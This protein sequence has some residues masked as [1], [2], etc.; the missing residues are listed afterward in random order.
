MSE[1]L[2]LGREP[3]PV[4][5]QPLPVAPRGFW[6]RFRLDYEAERATGLST[7]RERNYALGF[8]QALADVAETLPD[9]AGGLANPYADFAGGFGAQLRGLLNLSPAERDRIAAR[10]RAWDET[11]ERLIAERP[12]LAEKLPRAADIRARADRR[13]RELAEQ[14]KAAVGF[15]GGLGGFLGTAAAIF[16]DPLQ[17]LTLA[18]G[19]GRPAGS[20]LRQIGKA[21]LIEGV[22]AGGVQAAVELTAGAYRAEIGA[23]GDSAERIATATAGGA[24]I[25]GGLRALLAGI[26]RALG[27]AALTPADVLEAQ[28]AAAAARADEM[29]AAANPVGPEQAAAHAQATAAAVQAIVRGE[30][31]RVALPPPVAPPPEAM[32]LV[33]LPPAEL[34]THIANVV[35][36]LIAARAGARLDGAWRPDLGAITIEWGD[37]R[38]GLAHIIARRSAEGLDGEAF[39]R[40]VVPDVLVLGRAVELQDRG[41]PRVVLEHDTYRA[42]LR[43][44]R[45]GVRENWLLS[46]FEVRGGSGGAGGLPPS[47]PYAPAGRAIDQTAGAEP[48]VQDVAPAARRFNAYTPAARAVLVE[49]R[50]VSLRSLVPSHGPDGRPNPA[51]PH[52]EGLQPRDRAAAPSQDQVRAIAARL[53]PERLLPNVEAGSGAPIIGPDLVVESGNGRVAALTLVHRDPAL[54][55]VREAYLDAL[56]RAGFAIDGIE[57]PVLVSARITPL[58][59]TER[60]AF[61]REANLRGTA[62]EM[63]TEAAARDADTVR[64]LMHL[65]RGGAVDAAAN[66]DFLRGFLGRLTPEERTALLDAAGRPLPDLVQRV[67]RALLKAAYGDELAPL[68]AKLIAG[69][70]EGIR[71]LAAAL[72]DVAGDWAAMRADIAAGRVPAEYEATPALAEAVSA[73]AEAQARRL[74]LAELVLQ[75]DL[76]RPGLTPAGEA[77]LRA[78]FPDGDLTRRIKAEAKI[79]DLLRGY[80]E[81]ARQAEA[82]PM[83]LDL[84]PVRTEDAIARAAADTP[85]ADG[86]MARAGAQDVAGRGDEAAA[87]SLAAAPA[88]AARHASVGDPQAQ[89]LMEAAAE[90]QRLADDPA[91]RAAELL[92]AQRIAAEA[93]VLVPDETGAVS[94][95]GLLD[96]VEREAEEAA[97]AAACLI[98]GAAT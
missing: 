97:A 45:D 33:A 8:E 62:A 90:A 95:R 26:D 30:E 98:G 22:A 35:D 39:V 46:A 89:R 10:E 57:E 92:E 70:T 66:R 19:A 25:G 23:P 21:A 69:E 2:T 82:G 38:A 91:A 13:A 94:A 31:P 29:L 87:T 48:R 60:V 36:E 7:S 6:E 81:R 80:V 24:V 18:F 96:A 84:P 71:G 77:M 68:V 3:R 49:P 34:R 63:L 64:Q 37:E 73:I 47:P 51:Y 43:L 27:R 86:Q 72:R 20:V 78:L 15:G 83:L 59:P 17:V 58:T 76:D 28:A 5:W 44:D 4:A 75:V 67:E 9:G 41:G 14:A 53:V 88:Q 65:W 52:A 56:R 79:T 12:E 54:A 50:V 16:T 32:R 74:K 85:P 1:L 93:D 40:S 42:V 55:K 11:V 61:V